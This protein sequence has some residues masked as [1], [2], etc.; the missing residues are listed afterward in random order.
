MAAQLAAQVAAM[1]DDYVA[2]A[3]YITR[4]PISDPAVLDTVD[5]VC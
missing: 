3:E 4:I 1:R 2:I 5:V